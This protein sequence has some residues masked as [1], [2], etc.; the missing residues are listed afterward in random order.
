MI[1]TETPDSLQKSASGEVK[2]K[3]KEREKVEESCFGTFYLL[4][5]LRENAQHHIHSLRGDQVYEIMC[6]M[7]I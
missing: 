5:S 6:V 1:N 3:E 4:Q 7:L 2:K